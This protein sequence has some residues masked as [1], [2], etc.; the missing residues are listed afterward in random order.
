MLHVS[1]MCFQFCRLCRSHNVTILHNASWREEETC[2][3]HLPRGP[4]EQRYDAQA[5]TWS[6]GPRQEDIHPGLGSE[7]QGCSPAA[8]VNKPTQFY[9]SSLSLSF[10]NVYF[11]RAQGGRRGNCVAVC[12]VK[13]CDS[14]CTFRSVG[15]PSIMYSK[16]NSQA[17]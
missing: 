6:N 16:R 13:V 11:W 5:E 14:W 9:S 8:A 1:C 17:Q 7:C 12:C 3:S 15:K 2:C 4:R 10:S